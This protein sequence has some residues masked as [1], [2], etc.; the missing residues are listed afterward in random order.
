MATATHRPTAPWLLQETV[1]PWSASAD[2]DARFG[3]FLRIGLIAFALLG[4]A[5]ALIPVPELSREQAERVPP[6]L[7]KVI[8]EKQKLPEPKPEP[9]PQP[10][11][12]ERQKPEP[13]PEPEK[14]PEPKPK[15]KEKP[16]AAKV[17]LAR[18]KAANSGLM[19]MQDDLMAMRDSVDVAEVSGAQL[20]GSAAKAKTVERSVIGDRAKATSGGVQTAS[21]SRDTGGAALA[22]RETTQV[23]NA[24]ASGSAREV[25]KK[26]RREK[27]SRAEQSIRGVMEANKGAIYA[28]YNRALRRDP[29]LQGKV[30]VKLVIE[31]DGSVSAISIVNSELDN[32]SLERKLLARIRLINF[33]AANVEQTTLNYSIDFLPS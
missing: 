19:Q 28:I 15:P 22:A 18:E 4:I 12:A 25:A 16:P 9:K 20:A 3:K 7:A 11:K 26:V 23:E 27:S 32:A 30:T 24:Q 33:G 6:Q 13:K 14:K 5:A 1:L 8:L 29:M 10:K 31:P 21:L 2:E 17:K